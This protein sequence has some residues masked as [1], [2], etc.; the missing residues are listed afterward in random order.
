MTRE[1]LIKEINELP[2]S[3]IIFLENFVHFL[4]SQTVLK[5]Q[6]GITVSNETHTTSSKEYRK[7]GGFEGCIHMS[8]DFDEPLEDMK[9]YMYK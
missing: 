5:S 6:T 7:A 4:K 2:D 3:S 8:E 9:E 1:A